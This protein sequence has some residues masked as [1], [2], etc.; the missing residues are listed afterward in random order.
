MLGMEAF[1]TPAG[2]SSSIAGAP[3]VNQLVN[4]RPHGE[5]YQCWR[6]LRQLIVSRTISQIFAMAPSFNNLTEDDGNDSEEEI[7]VSGS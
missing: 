2:K 1:P 4:K 3:L 5:N 7:D 6:H